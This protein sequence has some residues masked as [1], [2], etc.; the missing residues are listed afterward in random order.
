MLH[1]LHD[2]DGVV[3]HNADRQDQ[4]EQ[5]Q[6]IHRIP[7]RRHRGEGTDDGNRHRCQRDRR[8]PP[9]LQEQ[10]DHDRDEDDRMRSDLKTSA[11]D[12]RMKGVVS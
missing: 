11:I 9:R 3:H 6:Q 4:T 5:R 12:S 7:H 2:H 1:R 10:K 8:R